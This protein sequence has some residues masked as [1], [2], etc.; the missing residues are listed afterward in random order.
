MRANT[1]RRN[2]TL[3]SRGRPSLTLK[4]MVPFVNTCEGEMPRRE[5]TTA[6]QGNPVPPPETDQE[7]LKASEDGGSQIPGGEPADDGQAASI[8]ML[9]MPTP[10][11]EMSNPVLTNGMGK[12]K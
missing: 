6:G 8:P 4:D 2:T 1:D 11:I 12:D 9:V 10:S 5:R 7:E 3:F